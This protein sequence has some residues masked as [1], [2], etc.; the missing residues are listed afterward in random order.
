MSQIG[1][2]LDPIADQYRG[3]EEHVLRPALCRAWQEAFNA[4]L[5]EPALSRC[6]AAIRAGLPWQ[7]ALWSN[8]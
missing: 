1:A 6:V 2:I 7:L 8:D 5:T 4:E 3:A